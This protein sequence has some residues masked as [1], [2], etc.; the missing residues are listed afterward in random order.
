MSNRF[1]ITGLVREKETAIGLEGLIVRSYDK[2]LIYDDLMGESRTDADGSFRIVSGAE[3]FRDLFDKR[4]D[5]YLKIFFQPSGGDDPVEIFNTENSIRWNAGHLQYV[6]VEI[7]H[8]V[9]NELPGETVHQHS[10]EHGSDPA[11]DDYPCCHQRHKKKK[12]TPITKC[13][14][15]YLKIEKLPAYSPVA[16]DDAEHD[17]YRRDCMRNMGHEDTN[18][19]Y[20]EGERRRLDA[21]VYREYLDCNYSILKTDPI[22]TAD[23]TEPR[24]ERR[25][26]GTV[27]YATPGERLFIHVCNGDDETH[28]FHVHGLIYGID[29]DGSWPFGVQNIDGRRSDAICPGQD[30]CYIFDVNEHTIGAWPFHDHHMHISEAVNRG[31]FGGIIVRDPDCPKPDYEVPLFYHKLTPRQSES[32]FDSG[33]LTRG[34]SFS[35]TF[36]EEGTFSYHCQ[37]HPMTGV[38]RVTASGPMTASVNILDSPGRFDPADVTIRVGGTVTWL[39]AANEPHTVTDS[40]GDVLESYA[41][42]GRTFV[43]NTPII[44][45]KTG[46]RIRWYVFNLDLSASWHNFHVHGQ[47]WQVGEE[48]MDSRSIG[49]AESFVADTVVPPVILLPLDDDCECHEEHLHN[50]DCNCSESVGIKLMQHPVKRGEERM[51]HAGPMEMQTVSANPPAKQMHTGDHHEDIDNSEGHDDESHNRN[52]HDHKGQANRSNSNNSGN[53]T[54]HKKLKLQGDFLVHCH[55]EMHMMEGMAAIVRAIQEIEIT[56]KTAK[57]L[58]FELPLATSDIC[59]DVPPHPCMHAGTGSWERLPD[60]PIFIVHAAHLH[61]GKVLLWSGTAEVGD[62]LES[63]VWDPATGTM[64]MQTYSVDLF[65][66]GHSFMADGRLC[67]AGGAPSGT[68][69]ATHIFDPAAETWTRVTDMNQ[70]R[71]YPTVLTLPDGRILAASGTGANELE[72]Y[73]PAADTWQIISG[74]TRTFS[75]LYPSLHLLPSGQIFYSRAGWAQA[76]MTS[77]DTAYLNFTGPLAGSW[78]NLGMQQ[79]SDRQE[80]TAMIQID[81]TVSPVA[82]KIYMIGGGVSA[83]ATLRNPISAETIDLTVMG[84]GTTWSRI[85]DMNFPRVNVNAVLLPDGRILVIGGQRNGKWNTDPGAV[86]ETEIYD[87]ATNSWSVGAAMM[88][89]RQYHS[90]AVLL[91]DGRVLSAGGVDPRPGITER[92]Q[93]NMEIYSPSYLSMGTRPVITSAPAGA[94]WAG[95]FDIDT[96]DSSQIDS[97][98][99]IRPASITHHTDA[100]QRYIR[101]PILSRTAGRLTVSAPANGNIAPPGYYML[102][103]VDTNGIPSIARF[104]RIG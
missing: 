78:I 58:G 98:V 32:R 79:F 62:P 75:E 90:I 70:A 6:L 31:L 26:P 29:S 74:A 51:P 39:H 36:P 40:G 86:L 35:Y 101:I 4:P 97:V 95:S 85:A 43:G 47:R 53:D 18:I 57:C 103:I 19:P 71:W 73:D 65:C 17:M 21:L 20:G 84:T 34:A 80:G 3:D 22:I 67:I 46:K 12:C 44:V 81:A 61:T 37:F 15:I 92:D 49:P 52:Q 72:I 88:F 10:H 56:E 33:T 93:R 99:L 96:P 68:L 25:I 55:V 91:T 87:P 30:W 54:H 104:I 23:I 13:R 38:V 60:S 2:D 5:I 1:T 7:P 8:A 77:T 69:S 59:S 102:F 11:E 48:L 63:R 14:D 82:A 28:S 100:G 50:E 64:T 24:A 94:G 27:I 89:P 76:D 41:F 45:A 9:I 42:N 66:S 16:P 83:A